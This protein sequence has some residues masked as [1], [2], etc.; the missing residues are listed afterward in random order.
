[1]ISNMLKSLRC[2]PAILSPVS[3]VLMIVE[4]MT[5]ANFL[6]AKQY[7]LESNSKNTPREIENIF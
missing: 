7:A 5:V 6:Q 1:M 3:T 2:Q 4:T